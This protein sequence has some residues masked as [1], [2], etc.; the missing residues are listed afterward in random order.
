VDVV[1]IAPAGPY[2]DEREIQDR[3]LDRIALDHDDI[4]AFFGDAVG[5]LR[6]VVDTQRLLL[7]PRVIDDV[8]E[9]LELDESLAAGRRRHER[10]G[11][12]RPLNSRCSVAA[13][14]VRV[15]RGRHGTPGARSATPTPAACS[16]RS[17][18]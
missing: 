2:G 17:S 9:A 3:A 1:R 11:S 12:V 18:C 4:R 15:P 10:L 7:D 14:A 6:G 8:G 16:P 5:Q 13:A